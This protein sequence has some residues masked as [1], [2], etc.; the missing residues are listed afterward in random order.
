MSADLPTSKLTN[1][2]NG[3]ATRGE[4]RFGTL[5]RSRRVWAVG[6]IHGEA[7]RLT[8]LHTQLAELFEAGDRVVYLGNI[9][10][11][12]GAVAA[13]VDELLIFRR[14]ILAVPGSHVCDMIFLRGSQE[15]MWHKLLQIHLAI[16]PAEVIGWVGGQGV[17]ATLQAY[18]G[19]L[20][21]GLNRARGGARDLA[22]WTNELRDAVAARPGHREYMSALKRAAFTDD[23]T[24]LFVHAGIDP[25]LPID[26]QKDAFWWGSAGIDGMTK[27]FAGFRKVVRG[28]APGHPGIDIRPHSISV[29]G[30]A[31]TGGSL[32]AACIDMTGEV[33]ARIET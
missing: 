19:S 29:D 22:R 4:V 33:V 6:A 31:G 16:N 14:Q 32:M 23:G 25:T 18:G 28:Y 17:E 12:G 3:M 1:S 15:E 26:A 21:E 7:A 30:G 11:V 20:Q 27:P 10:G 5:R 24:L 9:L 8:Q 13:T 2:P